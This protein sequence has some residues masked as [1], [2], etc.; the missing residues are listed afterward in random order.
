MKKSKGNG[1]LSFVIMVLG[2]ALGLLIGRGLEF[3]D[4]GDDLDD[5]DFDLDLFND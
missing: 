3:Y 1:A 4:R 5:D 2:F